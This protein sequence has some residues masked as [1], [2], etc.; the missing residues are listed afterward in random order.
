LR[1]GKA[2]AQVG[3]REVG[4]CLVRPFDQTNAGALKVFVES[5]IKIFFWLFEPIKIKVIQV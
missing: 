3:G 4:A 1:Q 5:R 2:Y